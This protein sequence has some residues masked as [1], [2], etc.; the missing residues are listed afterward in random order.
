MLITTV[1][2]C[3]V[4]GAKH[5]PRRQIGWLTI[6]PTLSL[7]KSGITEIHTRVSVG[8]VIIYQ[9]WGLRTTTYPNSESFRWASA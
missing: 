3:L 9:Q 1:A 4:L 5:P 8:T 6:L 7:G 2:L